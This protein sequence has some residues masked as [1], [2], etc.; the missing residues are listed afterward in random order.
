MRSINILE[1]RPAR[2]QVLS[3]M[4]MRFSEIFDPKEALSIP[5]APF[6][7]E[8]R[9]VYMDAAVD[10]SSFQLKNSQYEC[11]LIFFVWRVIIAE[12]VI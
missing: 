11:L 1:Q 4:V 5:P 8:H 7:L 10:R 3:E 9:H 2:G 6:P 12:Q